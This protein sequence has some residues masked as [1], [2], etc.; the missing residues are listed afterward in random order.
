MIVAAPRSIR[1]TVPAA[2][3]RAPKRAR[4]VR[5]AS[6]T[7]AGP[8][9]RC[10]EG[11]GKRPARRQAEDV[12]EGAERPHCRQPTEIARRRA[13]EGFVAVVAGGGA[14]RSEARAIGETLRRAA[15]G[16]AG[17]QLAD[18]D[19]TIGVG[20]RQRPH[21]HGVDDGEERGGGAQTEAERRERHRGVERRA[22]EAAQRVPHVL[23][24]GVEPGEAAGV[25]ALVAP[26]GGSIEASAR[27]EPGGGGIE[28]AGARV[29]LDH[30]GVER[31]LV[32]QLGV[33]A[34]A[35]NQRAKAE[36]EDPQGA[37]RGDHGIHVRPPLPA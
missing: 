14:D 24:Q 21:E 13:H 10:S 22:A 25:A 31:E 12:E 8:S 9:P 16:L 17:A 1:S 27:F 37:G 23:A 2:S 7:T 18:R 20:K 34:P 4:Q 11:V 19:D 32:V 15:A 35:G 5:S 29:V 33:D 36:P 26:E 6:R 3:G 30:R 28:A